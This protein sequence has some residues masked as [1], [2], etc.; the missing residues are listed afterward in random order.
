MKK[1]L[2]INKKKMFFIVS[3]A[4]YLGI[5]ASF[6]NIPEAQSAHYSGGF[7][8]GRL[9][10]GVGSGSGAIADIAAVQ[11]GN[12]TSK[13]KLTRSNA[14]SNGRLTANV[15]THFNSTAPPTSGALGV[16]YPYKTWNGTSGSSANSNDR[17]VK[18]IVYQY[19]SSLLNTDAKRIATSTHEFGHAL[20]VAHP[21]SSNTTAVMRQ[22]VK[23]SY[24]LTSYDKNS[25]INKWGK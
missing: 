6:L 10:Y 25:L 24:T 4:V 2:L 15:I 14:T 22:G 17:W 3:Y 18:A 1:K 5:I 8:T 16:M 20:S 21:S 12:V 13:A 19:K 7:A 9:T 23:T 11:W